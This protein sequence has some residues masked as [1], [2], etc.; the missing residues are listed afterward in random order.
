MTTVAMLVYCWYKNV[1]LLAKQLL[2]AVKF[3]M[4]PVTIGV[5]IYGILPI[6]ITAKSRVESFFFFFFFFFFFK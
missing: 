2:Q 4:L 1:V 3:Q 6:A 5:I